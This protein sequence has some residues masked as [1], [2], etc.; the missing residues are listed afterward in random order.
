MF[1]TLA[2]A[3]ALTLAPAQNA[4][5]D[6]SN[7]RVTFGGEFGPT[8]PNNQFLPGDIFFFVFD[9]DNLKVDEYGRA[10]YSIGMEV[11]DA[12]GKSIYTQKP[13]DQEALMLLGGSKLPAHAYVEIGLDQA[14]GMYNCKV[15]VTEKESKATK[16]VE[17]KYEVLAP[18]FGTVVLF[19]SNDDKGEVQSPMA[20]IAG[21]TL[22]LHFEVV[23]FGRN[24]QTKEINVTAEIR[25]TDKDGKAT[26]Q[27]PLQYITD[28][29]PKEDDRSV[30]YHIGLP[31]NRAGV[32][33]VTLKTECKLT[34]KSYSMSFPIV[35]SP[36]PK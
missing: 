17:T 8:R 14:K 35:V 34:G 20:G 1:P 10:K 13:M 9:I 32:F 21:Q 6:I 24:P 33:N 15:T 5:L 18:A 12:A 3:A 19:T 27:K 11:T 30:D 31:L 22:W 23:N 29:T 16:S 26:T 7:V 25:V 2:L 4:A 36:T 28:K